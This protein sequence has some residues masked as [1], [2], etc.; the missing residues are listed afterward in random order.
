MTHPFVSIITPTWKRNDLLFDRCV[1]SVVRQTYPAEAFEHIVVSDGPDPGLEFMMKISYPAARYCELPE[2]VD[3]HIGNPARLYGLSQAKG[4]YIAYLDD[5]D[6]Y[7]TNHLSVLIDALEQHSEARWARSIMTSHTPFGTVNIGYGEPAKG[8][9][10]T[11][12][13]VHERSLLE[14]ATWGESGE[15]EDWELFEAWIKAGVPG[16][17]VDEATIDVWP[18]TYYGGRG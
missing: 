8:N 9:I 14:V 3:G 15:S 2:H 5:D 10:G 13:V 1:P 18:S 17:M 7:R 12:M 4:D 6:A 16:V 11:P